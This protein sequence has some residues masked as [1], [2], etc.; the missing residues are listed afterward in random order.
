[1]QGE[2]TSAT[3]ALRSI[4]LEALRVVHWAPSAK[5]TASKIAKRVAADRAA[6]A[7]ALA[8]MPDSTA[9]VRSGDSRAVAAAATE[10]PSKVVA[11][12]RSAASRAREL[13]AVLLEHIEALH[14]RPEDHGATPGGRT[15]PGVRR[16]D[17][18][19]P[20]E[21]RVRALLACHIER[22]CWLGERACL[23]THSAFRLL[24]PFRIVIQRVSGRC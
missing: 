13:V 19:L 15:T 6:P 14:P 3:S 1:M 24:T 16:D 23:W 10:G 20:A 18:M 22:V 8:A 7:A 17:G 9:L 11:Q 21:L 12:A 4:T 5:R 2:L